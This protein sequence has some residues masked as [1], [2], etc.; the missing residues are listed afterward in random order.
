MNV[1]RDCFTCLSAFTFLRFQRKENAPSYVRRVLAFFPFVGL[2]CGFL[3]YLWALFCLGFHVSAAFF[4]CG[5]VALPLLFTRGLH[6]RGFSKILYTFCNRNRKN[7]P[8]KNTPTP[9]M[10]AFSSLWAA[11]FLLLCFG[12]W[13][14]V[15]SVP[16]ALLVIALQ[17]VLSRAAAGLFPFLFLVLRRRN[18]LRVFRREKNKLLLFSLSLWG[19]AT[20]IYMFFIHPLFAAACVV[21]NVLVFLLRLFSRKKCRRLEP[22]W[23]GCSIVLSEGLS[24]L[25]CALLCSILR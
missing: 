11:L 4:A 3:F 7:D 14:E 22:A 19:A 17:F 12:A 15:F 20:L 9:T 25:L 21:S 24:L 6:M 8:Q 2:I 16:A 1:F 13:Q 18:P 5:A 10:D 23:L